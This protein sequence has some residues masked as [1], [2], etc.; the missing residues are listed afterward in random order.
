M[1]NS[2]RGIQNYSVNYFFQKK[3]NHTSNLISHNEKLFRILMKNMMLINIVLNLNSWNKT[4]NLIFLRNY[5]IKQNEKKKKKI[6]E[7]SYFWRDGYILFSCE[8]SQRRRT[9]VRATMSS[10]L[11][12]GFCMLDEVFVKDT[13]NKR[14]CFWI[15]CTH[16][17]PACSELFAWK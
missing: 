2:P 3:K 12:Y 6:L 5:L 11:T 17:P 7:Y 16:G 8:C 9:S 13:V 4:L 10:T 14:L 1:K 15:S